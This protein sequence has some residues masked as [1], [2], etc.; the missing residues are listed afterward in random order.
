MNAHTFTGRFDVP[1]AGG[2]LAVSDPPVSGRRIG[3]RMDRAASQV[4]EAL[5]TGL[6]P[7]I[8]VECT[9]CRYPGESL[10][11]SCRRLLYR[12][13]AHPQRVEQYARHAS[14]LRIVA[15]GSYE[16]EL[17]SCI[18][19]FKQAGRTDVIAPLAEVLSRSIRAALGVPSPGGSTAQA[20]C[21]GVID[22]VPIPSSARALRRRWYDPV[23]VLLRAAVAQHETTVHVLRKDPRRSSAPEISV[24]QL[25]I[26]PW[27]VHTSRN[28]VGALRAVQVRRM[29]NMGGQSQK[30]KSADQRAQAIPTPFDLAMGRRDHHGQI[31]VP[32]RVV[33]VDD[34]VTTGAT[35]NRARYV[36]EQAGANV[37]G[38]VTLAAV[39]AP[40]GMK[41][42]MLGNGAINR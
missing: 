1:V 37:L 26:V 14:G 29:G 42:V 35:L 23:A 41:H 28:P 12:S 8:P 31:Q 33:L 24:M 34:V 7:L 9:V 18:L 11:R 19:A 2:A 16:H 20:P 30:L 5:V 15:A 3:R 32:E 10:C 4:W 39:D 40:S 36:L 27:L 25:R 21:E 22:L 6:E 17:A 38:A 13:T